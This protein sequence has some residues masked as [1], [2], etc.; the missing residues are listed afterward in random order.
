MKLRLAVEGSKKEEEDSSFTS[1]IALDEFFHDQDD[2]E[3]VF[4]VE[5]E[6]TT[7]VKNTWFLWWRPSSSNSSP[8]WSALT[9]KTSNTQQVINCIKLESPS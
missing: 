8:I 5:G 2:D 4:N 9:R 3:Y 1:T 6:N 7:H